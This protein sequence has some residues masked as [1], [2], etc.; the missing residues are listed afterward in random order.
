MLPDDSTGQSPGTLATKLSR[1]KEGMARVFA[2]RVQGFLSF[3]SIAVQAMWLQRS[4]QGVTNV[5][6][7]QWRCDRGTSCFG[8]SQLSRCIEFLLQADAGI[9]VHIAAVI[10][11]ASRLYLR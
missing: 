7:V 6:K 3:T 1:C 4:C 5:T 8:A 9:R 2:I 11:F 10:F